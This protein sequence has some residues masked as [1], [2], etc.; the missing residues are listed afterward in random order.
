VASSKGGSLN[1]R[2]YWNET[3]RDQLLDGNAITRYTGS[4][5]AN[6]ISFSSYGPSSTCNSTKNTP[7]LSADI[8]GDWREEVILHT[9][10]DNGAAYLGIYSTNTVTKYAVPTLMRDHTYRMGVC[11]QNT[12]Y[13]QPPHLGYNLAEA[14]Q[15]QMTSP[16]VVNASLGKPMTFTVTT[17]KAQSIMVLK[18]V[19]PSGTSRTYN[20]PT[21][22]TSQV[23]YNNVTLAINGTPAEVGDYEITLRITG[24]GNDSMEKTLTIHVTEGQDILGD[25][26]GDGEVNV[27]DIMAIINIMANGAADPAGSNA[28]INGDGEVNVGDIMAII[29]IMATTQ[30]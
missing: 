22:F 9:V 2:V 19:T 8:L 21:G 10:E 6:V 25:I 11:W 14:N 17:D 4:S 29:N 26:N 24:F 1:F 3:V 23:D 15:P 7:N 28:D 27:G 12:A 5:F 16:T 20:V 13:N 30:P 18:S